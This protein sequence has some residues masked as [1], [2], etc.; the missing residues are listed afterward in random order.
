MPQSGRGAGD[1]RPVPLGEHETFV[2][3]GTAEGG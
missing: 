3:V 2:D 1:R